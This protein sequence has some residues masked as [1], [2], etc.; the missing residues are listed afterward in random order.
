[1]TGYYLQHQFKNELLDTQVWSACQGAMSFLE[2]TPV[3]QGAIRYHFLPNA[4]VIIHNIGSAFR[5]PTLNE[6][7][8]QWG[9]NQKFRT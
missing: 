9:G 8:S 4:S 1:M 6:L 3:G 7:Y 5:A 2:A